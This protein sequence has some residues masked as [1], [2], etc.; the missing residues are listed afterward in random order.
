VH[1]HGST[2]EASPKSYELDFV[3]N[4]ATRSVIKRSLSR[5]NVGRMFDSEN[6]QTQRP[7]TFRERPLKD[8]QSGTNQALPTFGPFVP[9]IQSASCFCV[10]RIR[11]AVLRSFDLRT[12]VSVTTCVRVTRLV[13]VLRAHYNVHCLRSAKRKRRSWPLNTT[14]VNRFVA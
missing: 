13:K 9:A 1:P 12:Q 2:A 3:A 10:Y 11:L 5:N 14:A 8:Y 4:S 7:L 6:F